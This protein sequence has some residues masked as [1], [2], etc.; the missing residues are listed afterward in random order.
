M[1]L[2]AH[3]ANGANEAR[4]YLARYP[5]GFAVREAEKLVAEP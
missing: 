1:R 3:S 5:H 4:R 2:L